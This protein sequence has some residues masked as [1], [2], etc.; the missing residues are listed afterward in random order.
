MPEP[1]WA[2][3]SEPVSVTALECPGGPRTSICGSFAAATGAPCDP[4]SVIDTR[5]SSARTPTSYPQWSR[6]AI[7]RV[8]I[9]WAQQSRSKGWV[10]GLRENGPQDNL[11]CRR[12]PRQGAP[13]RHNVPAD[14]RTRCACGGAAAH[15]RD[16]PVEHHHQRDGQ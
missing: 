5:A 7:L 9:G 10:N 15:S 11:C 6:L 3:E 16:L 14:V 8:R 4:V 2:T 13:D 12:N 1:A